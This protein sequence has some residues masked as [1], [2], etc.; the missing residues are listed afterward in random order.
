MLGYEILS[1][2]GDYCASATIILS[3]I[4]FLVSMISMYY[5]GMNKCGGTTDW[6]SIPIL[7]WVRVGLVWEQRLSYGKYSDYQMDISYTYKWLNTHQEMGFV[8]DNPPAK[9]TIICSPGMR[10]A[11]D[12]IILNMPKETYN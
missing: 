5:H 10:K 7:K 12:K 3:G 2:Q 8:Q 11:V 4:G 6:S 9:V 1:N